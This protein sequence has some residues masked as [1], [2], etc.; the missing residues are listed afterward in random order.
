MEYLL[1]FLLLNY[2]IAAIESTVKLSY[3]KLSGTC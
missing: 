1:Y 3:I 2:E